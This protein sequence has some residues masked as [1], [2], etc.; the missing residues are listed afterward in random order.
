MR[1]ASCSWHDA[2]GCPGR[3]DHGVGLL[4]RHRHR[5]L[6][7]DVGSGPEGGHHHV[8]VCGVGGED[9]DEV[10]SLA[11]EGLVVPEGSRTREERLALPEPVVAAVAEGDDLRPR[12]RPIAERVQV[13][14]P[15]EAGETH[16]QRLRHV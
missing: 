6:D 9:L 1:S 15:A 16:A 11:E 14:D 2:P 7:G 10:E 13:E 8:V 5:L 4:R 12:V 3:G